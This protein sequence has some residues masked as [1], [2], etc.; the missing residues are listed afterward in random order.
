MYWIQIT[1]NLKTMECNGKRKNGM[2]IEQWK[3]TFILKKQWNTIP[4]DMCINIYKIW[5]HVI[6]HRSVPPKRYTWAN[7][8]EENHDDGL[9]RT[10]KPSIQRHYL[11]DHAGDQFLLQMSCISKKSSQQYQAQQ[12]PKWY[13]WKKVSFS[14]TVWWLLFPLIGA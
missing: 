7:R 1:V 6:S 2:K 9:R 13:L 11:F 3:K 10:R 5:K 4:K 8:W 14:S 12:R